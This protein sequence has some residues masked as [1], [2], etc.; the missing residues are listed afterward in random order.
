MPDVLGNGE[1]GRD[2]GIFCDVCGGK[3][4][5]TD[6]QGYGLKGYDCEDCGESIQVQYD[7]DEQEEDEYCYDYDYTDFI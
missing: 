3:T 4:Y 1:Y 7:Y 2:D 6:D 5:L